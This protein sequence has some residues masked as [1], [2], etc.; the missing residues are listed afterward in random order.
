MTDGKKY[1][2]LQYYSIVHSM[3]QQCQTKE[4][5]ILLDKR[6]SAVTLH[7]VEC[8]CLLQAN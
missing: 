2:T 4:A 8:L 3:I 7:I 6:L 1:S 5:F